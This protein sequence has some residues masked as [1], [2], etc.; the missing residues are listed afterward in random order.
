MENNNYEIIAESSTI[1]KEKIK[2]NREWA[3][4]ENY[5]T[6]E[7][8]GTGYCD[9]LKEIYTFEDIIS[10]WQFWNNYPGNDTKKIFYNGEYITYFFK[11]K[12]RINALNLFVK[13]IRP[14]WE[15]EKNA[16]GKIFML[17]YEITNNKNDIEQFLSAA[18]EIW[19]KLLIYLIGEQLPYSENINGVRFVDKTKLGKGAV[20]KFEVWANKNMTNK[21]EIE[22][23]KNFLS[24]HFKSGII[25]KNIA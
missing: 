14:E 12:Y 9:L 22:T 15:D 16:K 18:N 3:F 19:S 7:K 17:E 20:F 21:D 10:F 4:W 25:V 8:S 1:E 24:E 5:A 2:L 23:L 11:E 6:K 13:G